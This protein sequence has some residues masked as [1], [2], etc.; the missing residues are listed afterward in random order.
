MLPATGDLRGLVSWPPQGHTNFIRCPKWLMTNMR[1]KHHLSRNYWGIVTNIGKWFSVYL[2]EWGCL[3][4]PHGVWNET[5]CKKVC[6]VTSMLGL[7][8]WWENPLNNCQA[9]G[10]KIKAAALCKRAF[11]RNWGSVGT[12]DMSKFPSG[13]GRL[14]WAEGQASVCEG[15]VGRGRASM[16]LREQ[17]VRVGS[18]PNGIITRALLS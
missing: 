9:S 2:G 17:R 15:A 11:M 3:C 14:S 1:L 5:E 10:S 8:C 12:V 13:R 18:D 7:R 16:L 6:F 4:L